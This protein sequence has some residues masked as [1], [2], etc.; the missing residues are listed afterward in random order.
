MSSGSTKICRLMEKNGLRVP[1]VTSTES[2]PTRR[3]GMDR[4]T[5]P[6]G[7]PLAV[8]KGL[9]ELGELGCGRAVSEC[10]WRVRV[11]SFPRPALGL[12]RW[13][14]VL[15]SVP[16][17]SGLCLWTV[18]GL[19][20][21]GSRAGG[22]SAEGVPCAGGCRPP[23]SRVQE[24]LP[25]GDKCPPGSTVTRGQHQCLRIIRLCEA[26]VHRCAFPSVLSEL[27]ANM[28]THAH[29][30]PHMQPKTTLSPKQLV[31]KPCH[32]QR[33]Y[34]PRTS[35]LHF[36]LH[37]YYS[38]TLKDRLFSGGWLDLDS[39]DPSN[40]EMN[41]L[42]PGDGCGLVVTGTSKGNSHCG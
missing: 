4:H 37:S 2:E 17:P 42:L 6:H 14:R 5:D 36:L 22:Y 27:N 38:G 28:H 19:S 30:R 24:H 40:M 7:G 39:Q 18:V 20:T 26:R 12:G 23:P 1:T 21:V 10:V 3:F 9:G 32:L 15:C 13:T 8:R 41:S 25:N 16:F 34:R 11:L 33:G 35:E 31:Q 29:T